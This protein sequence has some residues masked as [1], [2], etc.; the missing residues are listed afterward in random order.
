MQ[1]DAHV[2]WVVHMKRALTLAVSPGSIR[3]ENPR[4]GCV[5]LDADGAVVGEGYHRGA[6]TAHA[7]VDA[8]DQAGE[9]ARGG[10]A[11]VTLEP[12]SHVGRTGPCTSALIAAGIDTVVFAQQDPTDVASGG[13]QVLRDAGV[14]VVGGLL[15]VESIEMNRGWNCVQERQR[16][17][18]TLKSAM[19]L[20]GRVADASGGP[21]H[22]TGQPAR[23]RAHRVRAAMDA[24]VVGTGTVLVDDPSLTARGPDGDVLPRQPIRVVVGC[25]PVPP[26]SRVLD[27]SAPTVVLSTHDVGEVLASLTSMGV[28]EVLLEGGPTLS[29]AFLDAGCVDA[30]LW[31][32]APVVLGDGPLALAAGPPI[33]VKMREVSQVEEDVLIE[34]RIGRSLGGSDHVHRDR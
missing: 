8:L 7:E 28:Q 13:G 11:I 19:S 3:G 18:V 2:E 27:E 29:R 17:F 30:V 25:R 23:E 33:D 21:T 5:I 34:G 26:Q 22:I 10:T 14:H 6:G 16:P 15:A 31:F 1:V 9:R 20:D 32:I 12:C 4:V 24:I